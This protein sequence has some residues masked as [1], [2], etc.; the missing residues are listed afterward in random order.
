V[1]RGVV[2][3]FGHFFTSLFGRDNPSG[4]ADTYSQ[5]VERGGHVVV[6]DAHDRAEAERA[7][8]LLRELEAGH[9]NVVDRGE[10]QP[11]R[12]IVGARQSQGTAGMVERSRDSYESA[13]NDGA[14][15][16]ERDRAM[17]SHYVSPTAGPSLRD[18]ETEQA[19]GLRYA[20]KDKPL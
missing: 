10:Q 7:Q 5:H 18:P 9:L 1:D 3:S 11:L 13:G 19:P 2:A 8:A 4:H 14:P 16:A 17:A 20:D 15:A 6:V 12:D